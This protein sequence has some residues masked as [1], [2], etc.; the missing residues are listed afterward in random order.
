ML[1][2]GGAAP[3]VH[4]NPPDVS[5]PDVAKNN[6]SSISSDVSASSSGA[7]NQA[8]V[9]GDVAGADSKKGEVSY[10]GSYSAYYVKNQLLL[11]PPVDNPQEPPPPPVPQTFTN[12]GNTYGNAEANPDFKTATPQ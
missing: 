10:S 6:V 2:D 11:D 5:T 8:P 9:S 4:N 1:V 12:D 7:A 3:K